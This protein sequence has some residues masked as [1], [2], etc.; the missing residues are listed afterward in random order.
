MKIIARKCWGWPEKAEIDISEIS[1]LRW[2]NVSG[3][4]TRVYH[5]GYA[6]YG[7]IAYNLAVKLGLSTGSHIDFAHSAKVIFH[8]CDNAEKNYSDAY[9]LLES[10]A[11]P[12]PE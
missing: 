10:K 11:G 1:N 4:S 2:D 5:P 7:D 3:W 8:K 12:R 9:H 6:L